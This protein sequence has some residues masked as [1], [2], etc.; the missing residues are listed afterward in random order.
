MK[1]LTLLLIVMFGQAT[2]MTPE[3]QAAMDQAANEFKVSQAMI[4]QS[5]KQFTAEETTFHQKHQK[6]LAQMKSDRQ[7]AIAAAKAKLGLDATW[8]WDDTKG[9]VKK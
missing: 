2:V 4:D 7:Q 6:A 1:T 8:S 5:D 9:W 3:R